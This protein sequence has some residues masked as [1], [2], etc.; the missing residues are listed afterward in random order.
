MRYHT[1]TA[2]YEALCVIKDYALKVLI[3]FGLIII[4][5]LKWPKVVFMNIFL[6]AYLLAS[7]WS[8][9]LEMANLEEV[10][11]ELLALL[12]LLPVVLT[13]VDT[14]GRREGE[15]KG[16]RGRGE[17]E[18]GRGREE[19][20]RGRGGRECGWV[21]GEGGGRERERREGEEGGREEGEVEEREG[22]E[23]GREGGKGKRARLQPYT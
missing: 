6:R 13:R 18:G 1:A 22:E 19:R 14:A 10:L 21:R 16:G 5:L 7:S 15:R 20:G 4:R 12:L 3:D 2:C 9:D 11:G 23:E 17:R 8:L